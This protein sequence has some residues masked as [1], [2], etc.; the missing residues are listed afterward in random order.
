MWVGTASDGLL[1]LSA[2]GDVRRLT[3]EDGFVNDIVES[4]LEDRDGRI[5]AGFRNAG[6]LC[7]LDGEAGVV[8]KCYSE[9]DGLPSSWIT[10]LLQTSDGKF[11]LATVKGLCLWQGEGG[12][13]VCKTYTEKNDLCDSALALAEDRDG[14]LWTGS[15]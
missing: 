8:K 7:L 1:R 14:N 10:D 3:T 4:L 2:N 11:W 9:K 12:A 15:R 5:W 13:S 6:G